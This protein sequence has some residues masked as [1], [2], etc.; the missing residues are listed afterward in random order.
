MG[1]ETIDLGWANGWKETPK[2]L[3]E[4]KEK[5]FKTEEIGLSFT[6]RGM[7][8]ISIHC[9]SFVDFLFDEFNPCSIKSRFYIN[10]SDNKSKRDDIMTFT[11]QK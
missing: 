11:L 10:I 2:E 3:L 8:T 9:K 6:L 4:A 1:K 5:G 7:K